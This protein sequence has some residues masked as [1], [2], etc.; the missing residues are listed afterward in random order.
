MEHIEIA[1][2]EILRSGKLSVTPIVNWKN[3]FQ[4]IYR[5]ATGVTWEEES[6]SFISPIPKEWSYLDWY[7][8][9]V[10]SVTSEMGVNLKI[11]QRTKWKNIS[12]KLQKEI[13]SYDR[14]INT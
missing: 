14:S 3:L 8:N 2:I 5:T 10:A 7:G 1:K 13:V 12:D 4:F 9:I 11:A 6:E